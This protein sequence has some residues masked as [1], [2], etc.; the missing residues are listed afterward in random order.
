MKEILI[1][2]QYSL[3][4]EIL[5]FKQCS[6][7]NE[8]VSFKQYLGVHA[9]DETLIAFCL[10][11]YLC[12]GDTLITIKAP[13]GTTLEVPDPDEV[14]CFIGVDFSTTCVYACIRSILCWV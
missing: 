13:S 5:I 11:C 9:C 1:F 14:V 6:L 8:N 4:K 2:K 3:M 12:R 7:M 10:M